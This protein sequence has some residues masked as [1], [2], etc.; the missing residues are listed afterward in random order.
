MGQNKTSINRKPLILPFGSPILVKNL[1]TMDRL[2][3]VILAEICILIAFFWV[4]IDWQIPLYLIALV[5][6]FQ[7]ATGTCGLYNMLGWNSCETIKRKDKNLKAAFIVAALVLAVAGSY[8]SI[9]LTKNI[10]MDDLGNVNEP[11]LLALQ[12]SG[13][14]ELNAT[15]E[16]QARLENAFGSFQTKYSQYQPFVTKSNGNFTP[17]MKNVSSAISSSRECLNRS[18]LACAH[19]E[20]EK[21]KPIPQKWMRE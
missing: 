9:V 12:H 14:G 13:Q 15:S 6:L 8:A 17:E 3:R 21:A 20:L 2:L 10:F 7:A 1:G 16:Q 5:M 19:Q 11:Y 4:A 18:D